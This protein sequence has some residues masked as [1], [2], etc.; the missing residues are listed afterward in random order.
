M[1]IQRLASL[2]YANTYN[3]TTQVIAMD[4]FIDALSDREIARKIM[5]RE[6][7]NLDEATRL[8]LRLEALTSYDTGKLSIQHNGKTH[9]NQKCV[10]KLLNN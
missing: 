2:A 9:R 5:E 10:K 6:P 3:E 7:H 4:A 8:A 1:D